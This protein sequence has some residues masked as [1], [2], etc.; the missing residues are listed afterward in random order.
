M[1]IDSPDT[2]SF[3]SKVFEYCRGFHRVCKE[4]P[5]E[6]TVLTIECAAFIA[7]DAL[8]TVNISLSFTSW[9][10]M[11]TI[12]PTTYG[13]ATT[14]QKL[15][16]HVGKAVMDNFRESHSKV[17]ENNTKPVVLILSPK[18]D[19]R[20]LFSRD[21]TSLYRNLKQNY[22]LVFKFISSIE[23]IIYALNQTGSQEKIKTLWFNTHGDSFGLLLSEANGKKL[24]LTLYDLYSLKNSVHKALLPDATV[25]F[26]ACSTGKDIINNKGEPI[27]GLHFAKSFE[28]S[29]DRKVYAA[30]GKIGLCSI[31]IHS[32]GGSLSAKFFKEIKGTWLKPLRAIQ[33]EYYSTRFFLS[34][35]NMTWARDITY[36]T[37]DMALNEVII[38]S[39]DQKTT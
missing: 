6:A 1:N 17:P 3:K 5:R 38:C 37:P 33:K 26:E 10:S 30:K 25:I 11:L 14:L 19:P 20:G 31:E 27:P 35:R 12:I 23:D 4:N 7:L 36:S 22:T 9:G 18:I 29:L 2:I 39:G 32:N 24:Y 8:C 28:N 34:P 15:S 21:R 16:N 13:L